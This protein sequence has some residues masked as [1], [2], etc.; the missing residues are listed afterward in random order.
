M[1]LSHFGLVLLLLAVF[2]LSVEAV[3]IDSGQHVHYAL[4]SP[5]AIILGL[6]APEVIL[7]AAYE[8]AISLHGSEASGGRVE[9]IPLGALPYYRVNAEDL[10]SFLII[11][12]SPRNEYG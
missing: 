4:A 1:R 2:S 5:D 3:S 9:P 7:F 6:E 12:D 8:A 11:A 10:R